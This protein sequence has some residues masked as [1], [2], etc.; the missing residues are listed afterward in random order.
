MD[1][2]QLILDPMFELLI[3]TYIFLVPLSFIGVI[4][5]FHR[6]RNW[7]RARAGWIKIRKKLSNFHWVEFWAKPTGRKIKIKGEEGIEFEIPIQ[8]EKG[9]LAMQSKYHGNPKN[10]RSKEI[11][12]PEE[13]VAVSP[14]IFEVLRAYEESKRMGK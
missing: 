13:K 5:L 3:V 10:A 14:E 2:I 7:Q 12:E 6:L 1:I 4:A 11:K 9:M 8:I